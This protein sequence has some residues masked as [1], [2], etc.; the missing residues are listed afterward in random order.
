MIEETIKGINDLSSLEIYDK[1]T[2]MNFAPTFYFYLS[3]KSNE[4]IYK[5]IL[6][7]L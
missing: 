3:S 5:Y 1:K 4:K 7:Q 6:I 2:S